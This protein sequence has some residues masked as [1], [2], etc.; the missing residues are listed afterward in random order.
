[1]APFAIARLHTVQFIMFIS[2]HPAFF[3]GA[4]CGR[5]MLEAEGS[6]SLEIPFL[7]VDLKCVWEIR[8][9]APN[10][11]RP[12]HRI[13]LA[14]ES[15]SIPPLEV[16]E[17]D[18]VNGGIDCPENNRINVY[19]DRFA[20]GYSLRPGG[21]C[22]SSSF[23]TVVSEGNVLYVELLLSVNFN[24]SS[25]FTF[26][27]KTVPNGECFNITIGK[28]LYDLSKHHICSLHADAHACRYKYN[29]MLHILQ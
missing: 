7:A 12:G 15:F 20:P 1:M 17:E 24:M 14:A 13:I 10:T 27:Y 26:S 23:Q 2:I 18:I 29:I 21:Y 19:Q 11:N 3:A 28:Y 25:K 22:G 8:T 6:I 16:T 5:L 9:V 4:L